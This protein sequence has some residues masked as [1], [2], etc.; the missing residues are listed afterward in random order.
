L[1]GYW[2][3]VR[4]QDVLFGSVGLETCHRG[5]VGVFCR[6]PER[7]VHQYVSTEAQAKRAE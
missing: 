4:L 1:L 2:V 5:L 6:A 3:L 7:N